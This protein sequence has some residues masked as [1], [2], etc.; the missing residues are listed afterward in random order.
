MCV[1]RPLGEYQKAHIAID[2]IVVFRNG[3]LTKYIIFEKT[4]CSV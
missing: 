1:T 3:N 2:Y 4:I